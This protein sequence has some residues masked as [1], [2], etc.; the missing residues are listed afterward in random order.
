M[1]QADKKQ[2]FQLR[3]DLGG[4]GTK[5]EWIIWFSEG[6]KKQ[7][8]NKEIGKVI[9]EKL[10]KF[11][12]KLLKPD[13]MTHFILQKFG[14][15]EF[16]EKFNQLEQNIKKDCESRGQTFEQ[17][18]KPEVIAQLLRSSTGVFGDILIKHSGQDLTPE[19]GLK[20][21]RDS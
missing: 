17:N 8:V 14:A 10:E 2:D 13:D 19:E 5:L 3:F 20:W 7:G 1:P 12:L 18:N 9:S 21:I 6:L 15:K 16:E 4:L 11:G